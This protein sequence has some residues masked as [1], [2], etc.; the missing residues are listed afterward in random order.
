M[1]RP[2]FGAPVGLSPRAWRGRG[3]EETDDHI[4]KIVNEESLSSLHMPSR[5]TWAEHHGLAGG[6]EDGRR[7]PNG[8][9]SAQIRTSLYTGQTVLPNPPRAFRP[10]RWRNGYWEGVLL[11]GLELGVAA[12]TTGAAVLMLGQEYA[13]T[14]LGAVATLP[15][16]H[17]ALDIV[18][19]LLR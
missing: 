12:L 9:H 13:W 5:L 17:T 7:V 2:S 1:E 4:G 6:K 10:A 14:A 15:F 18:V 3:T 16:E 19:V 8:P 11:L